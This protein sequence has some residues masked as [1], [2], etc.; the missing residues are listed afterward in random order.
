LAA[1]GLLC[2]KYDLD[3]LLLDQ[4]NARHSSLGIK[5]VGQAGA[6]KINSF[7]LVRIVAHG[8]PYKIMLIGKLVDWLKNQPSQPIQH[9]LL[10]FNII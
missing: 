7:R 9:T 5:H 8:L 3:P 2:W 1:A 6:E 4:L 10:Y